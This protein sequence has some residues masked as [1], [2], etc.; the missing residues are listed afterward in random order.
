VV[1]ESS[2]QQRQVLGVRMTT[3]TYLLIASVLAIAAL[4]G[5]AV[6]TWLEHLG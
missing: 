2:R 3:Q 5:L 6:L 1:T 4:I